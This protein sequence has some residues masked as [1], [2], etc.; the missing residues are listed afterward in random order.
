MEGQRKVKF[1]RIRGRIVP[2]R[3]KA[4]DSARLA[5]GSALAGAGVASIVKRKEI[6]EHYSK[7]AVKKGA[8]AARFQGMANRYRGKTYDTLKGHFGKPHI[9]IG[10]PGQ[11]AYS[12]LDND[13]VPKH[14]KSI[15]L[16]KRAGLAATYGRFAAA[17]AGRALRASKSGI[18][19][20]VAMG[21]IGGFLAVRG[22]S[23]LAT[24]IAGTPVKRK[25]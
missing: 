18:A 24:S 13:F 16:H 2:I 4:G 6:A 22:A 20:S 25:K 21:A 12:L 10:W 23:G 3:S 19:T 1:V 8:Q 17:K 11:P 14:I 5:G 7:M 9:G 15:Q